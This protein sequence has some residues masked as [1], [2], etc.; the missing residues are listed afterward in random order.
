MPKP[1]KIWFSAVTFVLA[2]VLFYTGG[3]FLGAEL[4]NKYKSLFDPRKWFNKNQNGS[5][6]VIEDIDS[7]NKL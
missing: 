2:E 7:S 3:F 6:A 4:F 1:S 5:K